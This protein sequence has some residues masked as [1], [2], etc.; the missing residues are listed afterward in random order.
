MDFMTADP[1]KK[2]RWFRIHLSTAVVLMLV[3]TG[4]VWA[5]VRSSPKSKA[6]F[7]VQRF[8]QII[9]EPRTR[10]W[11]WQYQ[12]FYDDPDTQATFYDIVQEGQGLIQIEA[13]AINL[14][15][16]LLDILAVIAILAATAFAS[17]SLIRRRSRK[18]Q[19]PRA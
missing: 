8:F 7:A 16:L 11:P 2:R 19:E 17:E 5:N 9:P 1:P 18:Q 6:K 12:T 15:L 4:L 13:T 3:A 10:G 14:K